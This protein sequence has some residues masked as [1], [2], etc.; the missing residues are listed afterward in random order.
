VS[1]RG[2]RLWAFDDRDAGVNYIDTLSRRREAYHDRLRD[3]GVGGGE[4][5]SIHDAVRVKEPGLA[6]LAD[7]HDPHG[8]DAFVDAWREG[9]DGDPESSWAE[10]RFDLNATSDTVTVEAAAS[11][12]P[13]LTKRF[14]ATA[15]GLDVTYTLRSD[16]PR[17]GLLRV[18]VNLGLHVPRADDRWV[19]VGGSRA[20][21]PH[22][23][24]AARHE[25]VTSMAFV[26]AWA[27]RRLE[28]SWDREATVE[29]SPIE[30]VSLSEAGAERVFQGIGLRVDLDAALDPSAPWSV[31]FRLRPT[32]ARADA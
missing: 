23:A 30:T 15:D 28:L 9:A 20:E 31:C 16:R 18:D 13:G 27:N 17:H 12:L 26:D 25:R 19:D 24:A 22:F 21:P 14:A 29:R 10:R 1:A 2:G 6:A 8:R 5:H 3:A 7:A 32:R 4:G 11:S